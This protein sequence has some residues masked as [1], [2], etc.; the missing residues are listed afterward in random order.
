VLSGQP[1][2]A[3]ASAAPAA[4]ADLEQRLAALERGHGCGEDF[5]RASW[6]WLVLLGVVIPALMLLAGWWFG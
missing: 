5:D 1:E 4:P 2:V 6:F 3:P